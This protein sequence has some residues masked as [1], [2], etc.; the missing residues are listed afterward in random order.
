TTTNS[1][2]FVKANMPA[3]VAGWKS[4]ACTGSSVLAIATNDTLYAWGYGGSGEMGNGTG[5][6]AAVTN[7]IPVKVA[8]P[9][10]VTA[11]A[12]AAGRFGGLAL[13]SDNYFYTWGQGSQGQL[14]N[15]GNSNSYVPVRV[16]DLVQVPPGIPN[17]L[18][19]SNGDTGVSTSPTLKWNSA[20]GAS[21]YQLQLSTD[22][23]FTSDILVNDSTLADT[24]DALSGIGSSSIY[25][26]RVRSYNNG[27]LSAYSAVDTFTTVFQPPSV[28]ALISPANNAVNLPAVDTLICSKA[29]GAAK[30]HWELSADRGFTTFVVNDS[31]IDT[32]SI[33]RLSA[34]Q[35]YYWRVSA[36][37]LTGASPFAGPDS[38]TVM[39]SPSEAP[40]LVLPCDDAISQRA[41]TLVLL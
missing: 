19:P 4:A 17:L 35:K 38:F 41:D 3:G 26:W 21:G 28:P 8:L 29:V 20:P 7:P 22:P 14:G 9:S 30:Y 37:N 11:E 5:G 36:I 1:T 23:A 2:T 6:T 33:A 15:G 18:S 34:G 31:T 39:A 10:G 25:Y 32:T 24:L 12:I 27:V 40:S 16:I 13:G